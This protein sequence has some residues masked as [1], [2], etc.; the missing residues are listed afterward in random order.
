MQLTIDERGIRGAAK[1]VL[2]AASF[3]L[4]FSMGGQFLLPIL[5]PLH[6]WATRTSG[7]IGRV[8]WSLPAAT[9]GAV[10]AWLA[11][12]EAAGELEPA[13]TIAPL[14]GAGLTGCLMWRAT[15]PKSALPH[16]PLAGE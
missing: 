8:L 12:Y 9:F 16:R 6:H 14:A 4:M 11:V 5:F 2:A 13:I 10:L 7:P 15:G 3:V 1:V